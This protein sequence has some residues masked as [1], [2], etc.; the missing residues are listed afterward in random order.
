MPNNNHGKNESW[1]LEIGM[2]LD[3]IKPD[4]STTKARKTKQRAEPIK[5]ANMVDLEQ[6]CIEVVTLSVNI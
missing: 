5:I 2:S 1:T 4:D 6:T 3:K